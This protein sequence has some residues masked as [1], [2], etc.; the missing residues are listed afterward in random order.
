M[1]GV[2]RRLH[3]SV[4]QTRSSSLYPSSV[5]PKVT[6]THSCTDLQG[7]GAI[8]LAVSQSKNFSFSMEIRNVPGGEGLLYTSAPDHLRETSP[9]G[10]GLLF[11]SHQEKVR[12]EPAF[13]SFIMPLPLP[14]LSF[15]KPPHLAPCPFHFFP[16]ACD[17][18]THYSLS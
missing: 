17:P 7:Y 10:S 6:P 9:V 8:G 14:L 18:V 5:Y 16:L 11:P 4:R 13:S 3:L 1:N 15:T 2:R 12:Q